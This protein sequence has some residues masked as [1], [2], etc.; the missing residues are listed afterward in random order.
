MRHTHHDLSVLSGLNR[1]AAYWAALRHCIYISFPLRVSACARW[2]R[3]KRR[4]SSPPPGN[5][6]VAFACGGSSF[7]KTV[8]FITGRVER[9][10]TITVLQRTR[11][12]KGEA[13]DLTRFLCGTGSSVSQ[14]GPRN[15]ARQDAA[16]ARGARDGGAGGRGREQP[17]PAT[18]AAVAAACR[19][20]PGPSR[21][22]AS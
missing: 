15:S 20:R 9:W 17:R 3:S 4:P 10:E 18:A 7:C 12:Q 21:L 19:H 2:K 22:R 14:P 5:E 1:V 8:A 11:A 16:R 13:V 6:T